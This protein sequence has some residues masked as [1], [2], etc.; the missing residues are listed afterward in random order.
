MLTEK[1]GDCFQQ[2]FCI[3]IAP[4]FLVQ[5]DRGACIYEVGNLND[6]LPFALWIGRHTA[7][8]LEIELDFLTRL[9]EFQRLG[10]AATILGNTA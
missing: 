10:L 5:P 8:I 2:R 1:L 4:Y 3:E 9:S 6:V 7:G